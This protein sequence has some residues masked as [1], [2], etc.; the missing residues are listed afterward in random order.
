MNIELTDEFIRDTLIEHKVITK[1]RVMSLW[2]LGR[3]TKTGI[4]S[5]I[6]ITHINTNVMIWSL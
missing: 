6:P 1:K 2:D 5:H 3:N 4:D